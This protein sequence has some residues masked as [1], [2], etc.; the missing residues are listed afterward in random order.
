MPHGQ[1]ADADLFHIYALL[2]NEKALKPAKASGAIVRRGTTLI[3][4]PRTLGTDS[5]GFYQ[6][7]G[8]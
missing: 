6:I 7:H 4:R 2:K 1:I 3:F 8:R 5:L